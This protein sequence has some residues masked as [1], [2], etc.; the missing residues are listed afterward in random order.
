MTPRTSLMREQE[1]SNMRLGFTRT[2]ALAGMDD[3]LAIRADADALR[4]DT[5]KRLQS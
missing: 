1:M 3:N 2:L 4:P 5:G